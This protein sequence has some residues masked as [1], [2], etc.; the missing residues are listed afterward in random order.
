LDNLYKV[1]HKI[2]KNL[3]EVKIKWLEKKKFS[4]C[5]NGSLE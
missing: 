1:Y 3:K 4:V 2:E 5:G